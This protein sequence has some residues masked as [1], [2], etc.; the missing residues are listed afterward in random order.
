[1]SIIL[2]TFTC[3]IGVRIH[4]FTSRSSCSE[5]CANVYVKT[6]YYFDEFVFIVELYFSLCE[7]KAEITSCHITL[8]AT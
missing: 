4:L 3:F 7:A 6:D 5:T 2:Y 1:M 8:L